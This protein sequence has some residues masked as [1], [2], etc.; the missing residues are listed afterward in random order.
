MCEGDKFKVLDLVDRMPEELWTEV[1]NIVQEVA[2]KAI[3]KKKKCK[4][5]KRS[6]EKALQIADKRRE[7]KSKGER[8]RYPQLNAELQRT[9]RRDEKAFLNEQCREIEENK[10]KD[11][12]RGLFKKIGNIKGQFHPKMST[13][14]GRNGKKN[15]TEAEK[16]KKKWKEEVYRK[17]VNDWDNDSGVV[18][19][20]EPD[21]LEYEIK[22]A[23]GSTAVNKASGGDGISA[24]LFKS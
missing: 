1:H 19:H 4:K 20:S 18:S 11:K 17:D 7:V 21:I 3:P 5:A 22:G 9:E 12:M 6:S 14:N 16:I 8:E 23:L 24:E 10:R 2:N 15:L 13:I